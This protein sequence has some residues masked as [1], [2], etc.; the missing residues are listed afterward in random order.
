MPDLQ[1][2]CLSNPLLDIQAVGNEELLQK[3]GLKA[4]AAI[5]A[6]EQ[7]MGL[8]D[9]LIQNYHAE[10]IAGGG[11]NI[12]RGAQYMLP[13][14]SVFFIGCIS[15]DKY[16]R[17]LKKSCEKAG[18]RTEF[19]IDENVPTGRCGVVIT[20][21]NRSLC[22]SLAAANE[23]KVEHLKDPD[24][25]KLVQD[26][27]IYYVE[28]YHLTVCVPAVLA[29]AEEAVTTDKVFIFNFSAPFI[30]QV[31]GSPL[32]IVLEY[33]DYIIGNETEAMAWAES[34][35]Q[36]TK[37]IAEIARLLIRLPKKNKKRYRI[38]IITQGEAPTISAVAKSGGEIE[39]TEHP[40]RKVPSDLIK[41][42]NGA[43]DAWAGGFCAGL[44]QGKTLY[45]CI[46]MGHWLAQLGIQ[47]LGAAYPYPRRTFQP[48][49]D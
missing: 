47:E 5:L 38:V 18:V 6:E 36:S 10:V 23:Y 27:K 24:V 7:H 2:L 17:L 4:N 41:D 25:W 29:L 48:S 22:T 9:D 12:A 30:P 44:V 42:T 16:G 37:S 8:Y 11:S 39:I 40:V 34:Q 3:Y 21:H 19:R 46:D 15:N 1:L 14:N 20:G 35:S 49:K 45:E 28:G 32:A 43:G 31:Y 13:P 26:T 33:A